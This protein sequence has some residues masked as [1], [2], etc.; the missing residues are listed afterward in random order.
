MRKNNE[1]EKCQCKLLLWWLNKIKRTD[2]K[3][4]HM[5]MYRKFVSMNY[6]DIEWYAIPVD[7]YNN[8]INVV[9]KT[10]AD[11]KP[12]FRLFWCI[13]HNRDCGFGPGNNANSCFFVVTV[14]I[15][16]IWE[17]KNRHLVVCRQKSISW[18]IPLSLSLSFFALSTSVS[19]NTQFSIQTDRP[20]QTAKMIWIRGQMLSYKRSN[21][22][23][24]GIDYLLSTD[25]LLF[26]FFIDVICRITVQIW[27]A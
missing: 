26:F 18:T 13:F 3:K 19:I 2:S 20:Q 8:A 5:F 12:E 15:S 6:R 16:S 17:M 1:S 22:H 11:R 27:N 10:V 9:W 23:I 7:E 24:T 25:F 21:N 14:V 4:K